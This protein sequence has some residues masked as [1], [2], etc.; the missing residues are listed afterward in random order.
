MTIRVATY[1]VHG[2]RDDVPALVRVI[3]ATR[4]DILCVQEVPRR[5]SWRRKRARLAAETGMIVAAGRRRGGTAVLTGPDVRVLRAE[6][7]LLR[8]YFFLER[9]ATAIA[10]VE[11]GGLRVAVASVH[12]DLHVAARARH[13]EEAVTLLEAA[14]EPYGAA[15][16]LAGDINEQAHQDTFRHLAGRLADCYARAPRGEGM[17]FSARRPAKRID[18][19]FAGPGL[20]IVSCGGV[21][22][23]PADLAAASDHLP[24]VAE[25][26]AS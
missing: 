3:R 5:W 24:V 4:P 11:S 25:L 16:V 8:F 7:H 23:D 2:M 1:N 19:V 21:D 13:A 9:R 17:T 6:T 26:R 18:A 10:V 15:L 14:A 22:A 12:L 20:S